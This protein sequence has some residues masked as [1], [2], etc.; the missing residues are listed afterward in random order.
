M[1]GPLK[2]QMDIGYVVCKYALNTSTLCGTNNLT[3]G[4]ENLLKLQLE[5]H[6]KFYNVD[7]QCNVV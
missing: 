1:I 4:G 6:Y 5:D 7:V 3:I 2:T